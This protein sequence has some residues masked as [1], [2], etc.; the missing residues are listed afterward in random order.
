MLGKMAAIK[1]GAGTLLDNSM[2]LCGSAMSDGNSHKPSNIP[3]LLA[4]RAG[5]T[6]DPGRHIASPDGT[7]LCNL[8]VSMLERMGC[9]VETFGDSTGVLPIG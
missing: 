1:E 6:V 9:P 8:Y 3:I 5:G 7:P 4:G 2:I